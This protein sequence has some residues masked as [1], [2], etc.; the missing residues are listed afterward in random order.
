MAAA[1]QVTKCITHLYLY[2]EIIKNASAKNNQNKYTCI[3]YLMFK[4][5]KKNVLSQ[6]I[7]WDR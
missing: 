5:T 3:L 4:D 1:M 6:A 7:Q 2:V